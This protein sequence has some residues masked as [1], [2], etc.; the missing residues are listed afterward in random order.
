MTADVVP[1]SYESPKQVLLKYLQD[2][3]TLEQTEDLVVFSREKD[4]SFHVGHSSMTVPMLV[5][6]SVL[7]Q[8]YALSGSTWDTSQ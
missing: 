3:K 7:L 5:M 2:E 4:G 1:L 6:M 8:Q